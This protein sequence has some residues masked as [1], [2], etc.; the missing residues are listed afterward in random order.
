MVQGVIAAMVANTPFGRMGRPEE[1]S[2]VVDVL[3]SPGV[4]YINGQII[5]IDGG[6]SA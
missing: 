1:V 5:G 2:A 6:F 3:L 4:G